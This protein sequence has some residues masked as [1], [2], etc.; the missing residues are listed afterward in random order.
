MRRD[1]FSILHRPKIE[2]ERE[3]GNCCVCLARIHQ[4]IKERI[5]REGMKILN[6]NEFSYF[7]LILLEN[8]LQKIF[9]LFSNSTNCTTLLWL[10]APQRT[11]IPHDP[12]LQRGT[13]RTSPQWAEYPI[14]HICHIL[15]SA[16]TNEG[17][18]HLSSRVDS[19]I[20]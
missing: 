8:S 6:K 5:W 14:C 19:Y 12:S 18:H 1:V 3:K 7:G 11:A 20:M 4:R 10:F 9:Q 17:I 13:I 2:G 16:D 15:R